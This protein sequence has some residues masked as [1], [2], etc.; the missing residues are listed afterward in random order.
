MTPRSGVLE[1]RAG[2]RREGLKFPEREGRRFPVEVACA[3]GGQLY[4]LEHSGPF[5][6]HMKL[7]ARAIWVMF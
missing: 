1:A 2:S 3:I 6:G 7:F 5:D 4:A